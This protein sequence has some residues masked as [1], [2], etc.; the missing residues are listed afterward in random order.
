MVGRYR[1]IGPAVRIA[2]IAA[3]ADP[4]LLHPEWEL[5]DPESHL[6]GRAARLGH[7]AGAK[8]LAANLYE[9]GPG[10]AVSPYHVH[11]GNEEMLIVVSGRPLLRTP[12][13]TRRLEPG[14]VVAFARG[15]EGAHRIANPD[16]EPARVLLLSTQNF[17][18]V[19]EHLSTGT[20]LTLTAPGEGKAF[21][22]DHPF[23]ERFAE[24][25]ALDAEADQRGTSTS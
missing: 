19:A 13:G 16:G 11:H 4:N 24:A 12:E 23:R 9:I 14:A 17:P 20:T 3:M 7:A 10:G 18:E 6:R 8:E 2:R 5:D 25:M 22:E 15:A 21:S 1:P